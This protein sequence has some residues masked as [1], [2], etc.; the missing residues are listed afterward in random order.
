MGGGVG[1]IY[2]GVVWVSQRFQDVFKTFSE[3]FHDVFKTY[4]EIVF[5]LF[6]IESEGET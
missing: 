6:R 3:R 1:G 5:N 4:S 2:V